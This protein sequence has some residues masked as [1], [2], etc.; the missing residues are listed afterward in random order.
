MEFLIHSQ[1]SIVT[2]LKLTWI[3]NQMAKKVCNEIPNPF[4]SFNGCTVEVWRWD[5]N[6]IPNIIMD[7]TTYPCWDLSY[8]MLVKGVPGPLLSSGSTIQLFQCQW[9]KL[10][11]LCYRYMD[12]LRTNDVIIITQRIRQNVLW[13]CWMLDIWKA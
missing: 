11:K 5:S 6:F 13:K 2:L 10:N 8:T 4:P 3:S 7:V 9:T 1:T 12:L